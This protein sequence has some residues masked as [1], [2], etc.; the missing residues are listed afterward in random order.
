MTILLWRHQSIPAFGAFSSATIEKIAALKTNSISLK[1]RISTCKAP[2]SNFFDSDSVSDN[3]Q[4][5]ISDNG[6]ETA[7]VSDFRF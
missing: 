7:H 4:E 5:P 3:V 2:R 6:S 1:F